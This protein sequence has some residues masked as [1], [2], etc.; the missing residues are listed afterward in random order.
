MHFS[1]TAKEIVIK[2]YLNSSY[3]YLTSPILLS[4]KFVEKSQKAV[5]AYT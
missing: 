5:D 2:T 1:L 3:N 4:K